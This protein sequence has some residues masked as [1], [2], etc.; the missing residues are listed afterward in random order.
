MTDVRICANTLKTKWVKMYAVDTYR[1]WRLLFNHALRNN[2]GDFLFYCNFRKGDISLSN[3]FI[4]EVCD[5]WASDNFCI[6]QRDFAT[7][8]VLNYD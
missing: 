1:P 4:R 3:C 5:T 6:P 7:Q 2:E 8:L